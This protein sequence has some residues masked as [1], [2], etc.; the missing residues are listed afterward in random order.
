M[1]CLNAIDM[2][3]LF[4]ENINE[5]NLYES[6]NELFSNNL[7]LMRY[8]QLY[9]Y[10]F[11]LPM[12]LKKI[13]NASMYNSV[14]SRSPFLSKKIINFSLDQDISKLYKFFNKKYFLKKSFKNIIPEEILKRKK[15][16]FAF[17]KETL[18]R[19]EK[20]MEELYCLL[21]IMLTVKLLILPMQ[22]E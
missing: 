21:L 10:K 1:V 19:D 11:Y 2:S 22:M 8:S 13:D 3:I 7:N 15:H 4:N 18:L 14:E 6:S 17:P 9:Y 16:G 12:I 5:E 20:L